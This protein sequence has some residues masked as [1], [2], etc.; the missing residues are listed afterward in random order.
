MFFP[1]IGHRHCCIASLW[2]SV[3]SN[4]SIM[5]LLFLS[6][7]SSECGSFVDLQMFFFFQVIECG[8]LVR[9]SQQ[10]LSLME[11]GMII[12]LIF[13]YSLCTS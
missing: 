11:K 9:Y 2:L 10:V 4:A 3:S 7:W 8:T 1:K 12:F 5:N 13:I 6:N